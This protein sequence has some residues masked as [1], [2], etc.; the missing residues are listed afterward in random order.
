MSL[1]RIP[2]RERPGGCLRRALWEIPAK[3]QQIQF[4]TEKLDIL[5]FSLTFTK[6]VLFNHSKNK[7]N[8]PVR[9][10]ICC[11]FAER[12]GFEPPVPF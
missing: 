8:A 4:F 12:G 1:L 2:L 6:Q 9:R 3:P 5:V 7:N 11:G 10:I